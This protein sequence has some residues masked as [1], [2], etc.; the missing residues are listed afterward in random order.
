MS[1][2]SNALIIRSLCKMH[3]RPEEGTTHSLWG[4]RSQ[5]LHRTLAGLS[6]H[7]AEA[8]GPRAAGEQC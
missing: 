1:G 2:D 3:Q 5:G 8:G 7:S 4:H 6:W